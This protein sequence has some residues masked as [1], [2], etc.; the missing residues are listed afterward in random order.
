M[1]YGIIKVINLPSIKLLCVLAI[2]FA[3]SFV[4]NIYNLYLSMGFDAFY[5]KSWSVNNIDEVWYHNQVKNFVEFGIFSIDPSDPDYSY[6]RTPLFPLVV[7]IFREI[8]GE[9]N[10]RPALSLA[11]TSLHTFGA[12]LFYKTLR[13]LDVVRTALFGALIYGCNF[14]VISFLFLSI[15]ESLSVFFVTVSIFLFSV[16][17]RSRHRVSWFLLGLSCGLTALISPRGGVV[18]LTSISLLLMCRNHREVIDFIRSKLVF[19][20]LGF[21]VVLS[22]WTIRNAFLSNQFVPLET[23]YIHHSFGNE[24]LKNYRLYNWWQKWGDPRGHELHNSLSTLEDH[25]MQAFLSRWIDREVPL[26]VIDTNGHSNIKKLLRDYVECHREVE[27]E[28][29][30]K[31]RFSSQDQILKC[32]HEIAARFDFFAAQLFEQHP[33]KVIFLSNLLRLR[34][35]MFNSTVHALSEVA[36]GV[37]IFSLVIK[38]L[39]FLTNMLHFFTLFFSLFFYTKVTSLRYFIFPPL[40]LILYVLAVRHVEARYLIQIYPFTLII[41]LLLVERFLYRHE[42]EGGLISSAGK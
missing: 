12:Y 5:F 11:Q 4:V 21:V 22:P 31:I 42:L 28:L 33:I 15:S 17:F 29:G 3:I 40:I 7:G 14:Q 19:V 1:R 23:Y 16:A 37:T 32:E 30:Y 39:G 9:V 36:K 25:A 27:E 41:F 8:F 24:G 2:I 35:Y 38:S 13:N 18:L 26:W 34:A 10:Y 20:C 6:R